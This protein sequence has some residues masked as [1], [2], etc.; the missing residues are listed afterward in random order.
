MM[1]LFASALLCNVPTVEAATI[2][3]YSSSSDGYIYAVSAINYLIAHD[4]ATGTIDDNTPFAA[5]GQ[6]YA[7]HVIRAYLFFDTSSIPDIATI[8]GATLSIYINSDA[9]TTDFNVTIQ[10]GAPTYPHDPLEGGDYYYAN[11]AGNGGSRNTNDSLSVGSYWDITL[12]E[13]GLDWISVTGATKL[14][15]RSSRDIDGSPPSSDEYIL[16]STAERGVSYAPKLSVTYTVPSTPEEGLYSYVFYGP[17]DEETGLPL[18]ENV[19]VNV[20]SSEAASYETFLFE[21]SYVYNVSTLVRRFEFVFEDGSTR[22]YWVDPSESET[23]TIY[24]FHGNSTGRVN[25]YT[26]SFLDTTSILNTYPYVTVKRYVNGSLYT[27]EKRKVDEYGTFLANLIEGRTYSIYL[28]NEDVTYVFGEL[29]MTSI[30]SIQLTLRGV[31]FPKETLLTQKY[32]HCYAYRNGTSIFIVFEDESEG[33]ES[34]TINIYYSDLSTAHS[35]TLY[36]NSFSYE[37]ASADSETTYVVEVTVEHETYG[38]LTFKTVL[39]GDSALEVAPFDLGFLGNWTFD[40]SM[41][42][43]AFIIL[44]VAG[45]FSALNAEVGAILMCV[46]AIILTMLGWIN[47]PVGFLVT[48]IS[49]AVL[50]AL[51]YHKRRGGVAY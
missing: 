25:T 7:Y 43:P 12:N 22:E 13:D 48:A 47:I 38:T 44:C 3:F 45:C 9:S 1:L 35:T 37:W 40:S 36:T 46:T 26:V 18:S 42:I 19:T 17:F 30:T 4:M 24:V 49:L 34:V 21:G 20:W 31:D 15:L 6:V 27:V 32:V 29:T 39:P 8:T 50:M 5:V 11:Y 33:T 14:V 51:V 41:L 23:A 2:T 10:S 28:G 16:F